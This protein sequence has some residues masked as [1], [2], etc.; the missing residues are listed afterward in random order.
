MPDSVVERIMKNLQTTLQ[1]ITVQNG[2]ANTLASV[3]RFKQDGQDPINGHA[4]LLMDGDDVLEMDGPL[5]GAFSLVSRRLHVDLVVIARQETDIDNRSASELMHSLLADIR[6]AVHADH[7]RG[8]DAVNTTETAANE[9]D[10]EIGMPELRRLLGLEIRYR[11]RRTD[12]T[13]AG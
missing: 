1:T 4:V 10:V 5:A 6:K 7:T 12:P 11:H 3:Q 2:Y 13:I 8:G 9:L